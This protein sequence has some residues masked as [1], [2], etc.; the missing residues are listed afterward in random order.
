MFPFYS[1][2]IIKRWSDNEY[3]FQLFYERALIVSRWTD[4]WKEAMEDC[5]RALSVKTITNYWSSFV[6]HKMCVIACE[7]GEFERAEEYLEESIKRG[8]SSQV[9][10]HRKA[11]LNYMKGN[12]EEA[13]RVWKLVTEETKQMW[14]IRFF[15]LKPIF[16]FTFFLPQKQQ[17][18]KSSLCSPI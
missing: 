18:N 2:V 12:L 10:F 4:N 14:I 6:M 3:V 15:F 16:L 11:I 5:N 7:M 17:T 13:H 9:L 8:I 1:F